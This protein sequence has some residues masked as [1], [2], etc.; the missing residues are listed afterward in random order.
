MGD[1]LADRGFVEGSMEAN[2]LVA[3][4]KEANPSGSEGIVGTG[5]DDVVG[6][7]G[8]LPGGV[9]LFVEDVK[10]AARGFPACLADGDRV[11]FIQ[12]VVY[13]PIEGAIA[14]VHNQLCHSVCHGEGGG[15]FGVGWRGGAGVSGRGGRGLDLGGGETG[16]IVVLDADNVRAGGR[17]G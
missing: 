1:G 14:E 4:D 12:F 17:K 8:V 5:G 10:N 11:A 9:F 2:L 6:D 16:G 15:D 13:V 7:N 3:I